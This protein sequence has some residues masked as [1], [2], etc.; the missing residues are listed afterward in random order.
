MELN[1]IIEF[2]S[3]PLIIEKLLEIGFSKTFDEIILNENAY[4]KALPI[5]TAGII[6][7]MRT[8]EEGR[9]ILLYYIR[10]GESC[11]MSFLGGLHHDTSK[12]KAIADEKT[13]IL[14]I[15]I[16]KIG[17][18][19]KEFPEW[20]EYI[21][22]LYHKRFEELLEVVNAIAFKKL[23]ERLLNFIKMKCEIAESQ[24]IYVTHGQLSNELGTA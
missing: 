21:F 15:P 20:L 24:A 6:K 11:I 10:A 1:D 16:D 14:F 9:E 17:L 19:M 8:D 3:S 18:L 22:R 12:V 2:K 7:V 13:E 23:D 5:V 4:I